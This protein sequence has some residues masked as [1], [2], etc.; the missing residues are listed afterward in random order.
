MHAFIN[1]MV[2]R[3]TVNAALQRSR[4]YAKGTDKKDRKK[5]KTAAKKWLKEFGER[6]HH[7]NTN[8]NS[9]CD[10]IRSLSEALKQGFGSYLNDGK[11]KLGICQKM[12]SL[13]LKYLWLMSGDQDKKPFYAVI[14]RGVIKAASVPK[15]P[16]WTHLDNI[17][18]Y[19]RVVRAI[20]AYAQR[21]IDDD[22]ASWEAN[23]WQRINNNDDD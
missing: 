7:S 11:I 8:P 2:L 12:I 19:L 16:D 1:E 14:D 22:G 20:D 6:Y 21:T 5:F 23:E 17:D 3:N 15:P 18:E 4:I 13:Y 10:E 9:W